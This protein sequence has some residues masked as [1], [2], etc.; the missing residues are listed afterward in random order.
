MIDDFR[1][2]YMWLSNFYLSPVWGWHDVNTGMAIFFPAVE[3]AYMAGK[4]LNP[5]ERL[6]MADMTAIAVKRYS[7][8]MD[9]RPDWYNIRVTV[10]EHFVRQKFNRH[11]DLKKRLID[12]GDQHLIEGNTWKDTFWG[13]CDGVGENNLGK[14]LMKVR[15]ELQ[16]DEDPLSKYEQFLKLQLEAINE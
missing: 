8:T 12:T 4:S 2:K 1:G 13:V 7:K 9:V 16:K 11:D 14:I 3:H 10:M 15:S 5:L 6:K